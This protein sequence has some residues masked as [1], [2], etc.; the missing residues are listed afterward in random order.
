VQDAEGRPLPGYA[1]A[2][3]G[4]IYGDEIEQAVTWKDGSDLSHVAGEAV[5]LRFVMRDADLYAIRFK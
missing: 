4:E 3:S 2:D 1:L 5:R